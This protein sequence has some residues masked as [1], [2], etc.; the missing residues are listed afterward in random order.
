MVFKKKTKKEQTV[1]ARRRRRDEAR[2]TNVRE[3]IDSNQ[4]VA[5]GLMVALTL[6]IVLICF[7]GRSPTGPRVLPGQTARIRVTAEIPFTY[8]SQIQTNRLIEQRK[9]Q[10]GPYYQIN[11]DVFQSFSQRIDQLETGIKEEL[12]PELQELPAEDRKLAIDTFTQQF[13]QLTGMGVS[14]EDITLL[15]DRCTPEQLTRY[16]NEG[17]LILR[18][19][20]RDG[21]YQPSLLQPS[22]TNA[23]GIV[24]YEIIERAQGTRLQSEED[25]GRL[26]RINLAGLDAD[27]GLSRALYR[28]FSKGLRPNLE[29][30]EKRTSERKEAAAAKVQ[31]VVIKFAAGDVLTEPGTKLTAEQVE[32]LNAYRQA[33]SK[34]ERMI[35]GFN[36]TLAEQT[37]L[38]FILILATMIYIQ[39]AMPEFRRSNRRILLTALILLVNLVLIRIVNMIGDLDFLSRSPTIQATVTYLAPVAFAGIVLSMLIGARAAVMVSLLISALFGMM[40]GNS[41]EAFLISMLSSLAGI[42]YCRDI[43]L[44]AKVVKAGAMAGVAV[45]VGALFFGL[46]DDLSTRT[47]I[48]QAVAACL[49]GV[50][51]G[52][53]AIGVLPLLEHTFRFTTDITL[54]EMTDFNHPLLRKL[55]I[56]APGTY[57][58]SL[59]VANLSERAALEIGVNPLLCRATCLFHDIGKIAKP[60]YFVENQQDGY[61]PHDDRNPTMSAL[62]IKNHV[63]EGAEMAREAK[64]PAVFLDVIRQHHGTTL[65]KFFYNKALNQKQQPS[66]PLGGGS[67]PPMPDPTE[68]DESSFRYDGPRPRSKEATIIFFADAIEAASRSL[69]KV[70]PQN[71]ED[72][73]NA[74]I[75]ERIEDGQLDESPLTL[76]EISRIRDSF[77][78]T[79]LNM[80]HSRVEYPKMAKKEA[81]RRDSHTQPPIPPRDAKTDPAKS[82]FV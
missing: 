32:A 17:K 64:L 28:I 12:L 43:R 71:V 29:Y 59:M 36:L 31:P 33:L 2:P 68:I 23:D 77:I 3:A 70:T 57:H 79:I 21:I 14:S 4:W 76:Q 48:Q 7:V 41:M 11:P 66:L 80:L 46:M 9:L 42:H 75:N 24:S 82:A 51:T 27:T 54:L 10:I 40:E 67:N 37:G 13:N 16:L 61:N 18:D 60:E 63:K 8:T 58:H 52:M 69:K 47:L 49:V 62:I 72:L 78:F 5:T 25:A 20:L 81:P 65:I 15:I 1:E 39:V 73:V 26:L 22:T 74:I 38:T 34:S 50:L 56:E 30:D 19:I 53:L 35:W 45:A 55:Q 6:A 44:R